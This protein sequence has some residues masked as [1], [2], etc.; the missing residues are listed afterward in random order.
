[1]DGR[2]ERRV[3]LR[4]RGDTFERVIREHL[5]GQL[6]ARGGDVDA[7]FK[8]PTIQTGNITYPSWR[9]YKGCIITN[10]GDKE[11]IQSRI[12]EHIRSAP[13]R[14]REALRRA[15]SSEGKR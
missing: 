11:R 5:G 10:A 14:E 4:R 8:L 6:F 15:N 3:I 12:V 2:E 1:M 9:P 7:W 13:A